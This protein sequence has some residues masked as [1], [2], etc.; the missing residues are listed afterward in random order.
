ME[1]HWKIAKGDDEKGGKSRG[2]SQRKRGRCLSNN[3]RAERGAAGAQRASSQRL[4]VISPF[5]FSCFALTIIAPPPLVG[6]GVFVRECVC[7]GVCVNV[8]QLAGRGAIIY[9][10]KQHLIIFISCFNNVSEKGEGGAHKRLLFPHFCV[11][12]KV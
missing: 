7:V 9:S 5:A 6:E 3:T 11:G 4:Y 2:E 12:E 1:R 8:M 10:G